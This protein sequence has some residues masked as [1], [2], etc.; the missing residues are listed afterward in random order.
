MS[1]NISKFQDFLELKKIKHKT[2][3]P[4]FVLAHLKLGGTADLV[5][6]PKCEHEFCEILYHARKMQLRCKVV[7]RMSNILPPDGHFDGI[8]VSTSDFNRVMVNGTHV[9]AESGAFLPRLAKLLC[10]SG[11]SAFEELSGI[12]ASVG[13]AVYMNAGAYGKEIS[14]MLISARVYD[15]YSDN[16]V[17]KYKE[18]L[19][20]A[21]R[22]SLLSDRRMYLLSADFACKSE[23]WSLISER[24]ALYLAKRK[25]TQPLS[26]PSLGSTF[27]KH[28]GQSAGYYIDSAGLKGFSVGDA[29]V[30][31][32][33]ANFLIN[34]GNATRE[35]YLKLINEV[36]KR[37]SNFH[38]IT[39]EE[40]IE[41][42][43]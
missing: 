42:F 19:G 8:L 3:V 5:A 15:F 17:T 26:Y 16:V 24:M 20:F 18:E 30:S 34:K 23:L 43:N 29:E 35:D 14:D 38:G 36:K 25:E 2:N 12:P 11:L 1:A 39:L 7:G 22:K 9:T 13:G 28:N 40:E 27:K 6:Y 41:Y 31:K 10:K 4:F 33:H 21:Y 32:I 37:V